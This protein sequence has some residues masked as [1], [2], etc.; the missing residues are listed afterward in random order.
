M[1]LQKW[2][3][4]KREREKETLISIGKRPRAF[5]H[6]TCTTV[7]KSDMPMRVF[8]AEAEMGRSEIGCEMIVSSIRTSLSLSS[9]S[10]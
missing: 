5:S 3:E 4:I 7:L 9:L 1:T 8:F 10:P 2:T 6:E